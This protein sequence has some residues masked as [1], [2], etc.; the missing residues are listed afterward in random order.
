MIKIPPMPPEVIS[1]R[2]DIVVSF[3]EVE[4]VSAALVPG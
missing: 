1:S 4:V 2:I 3:D